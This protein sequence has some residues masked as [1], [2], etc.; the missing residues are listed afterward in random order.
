MR[1][2]YGMKDLS[3]RSF[4]EYSHGMV[5]EEEK[6]IRY[7]NNKYLSGPGSGNLTEG[8]DAFCRLLMYCETVA[9][10]YDEWQFCRD[11]GLNGLF[12]GEAVLTL[13]QAFN[14][15]WYEQRKK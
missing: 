1:E 4:A 2:L 10:D 8:C 3:P 13:E 5:Y 15:L 12:N 14:S 11:N 9:G 7:R 6:A